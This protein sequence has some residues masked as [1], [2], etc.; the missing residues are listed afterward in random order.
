MT[1][2]FYSLFI[3][4]CLGSVFVCSRQFTD[5]Y[6][7]PKWYF[8]L[9]MALIISVYKATKALF[10]N[11]I[12]TT[13]LTQGIIIVISCFTQAIFG[14]IQ[15]SGFFQ[16]STVFKVTGSFDNPAGFAACLCAGFPFVGF[17]LSD[18]NKYIRYG[19]WMAGFVI[20]IAVI[21]SQSRAGIM[22]IAFICFIL[23]N[24]KV[25][26]KRRMKYLSLVCLALLLSGCYWMKKDSADGRLLIW[27]CSADMIKDAPWFGHGVGSFEAHYMDY[28]ANYFR[29]HEESRYSMLADNV[30]HPF[31]EYVGVLLN[32]G[33]TGLFTMLAMITLIMYCYKKQPCVEKRT[34][35]YSLIS[36]SVFSFFSYPFT[37]P[38]TW[39]VML[40]CIAI[41]TREY[42]VMI[43]A[44]P[45]IKNVVCVF[46]LLCSLGGVYKLVERVM[47]EKEWGKMS[48]LA[49]CGASG[50]TLQD[51]KELEKKFE[52][53]PYFL[54]NYAAIL[55]ENEQYEESL[56]VAL[57]CRKYWADYDLELIIGENYQELD[58]HGLAEKYYDN[59]SMMCPSRFLPLY[60]LFHLYKEEDD[61]K[62]MLV[63]ARTIIDKPMKIKTSAIRMM[64]REME[65]EQTRLLAEENFE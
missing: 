56:K 5:S 42:V 3:V 41:L 58:E 61:R 30:K 32:F 29:Q 25:F 39:I 20:A 22:S 55:L 33:F 9:F 1:R 21:L 14:I 16:V 34:A 2:I 54:Y 19:G 59:A 4:L 57:Q 43:L 15:F 13:I 17:L 35:L 44:R 11:Q 64:K 52:D 27:R 37:Y 23:L 60:K 50:K 18:K 7:I 47:A 31:N 40:L 65:K 51:Y 8:V 46:V 38:F 6:I 49:L 53:N 24:R 10:N 26:H 45:M 48:G 63:V 12:K 28:Q 36:I 62:R